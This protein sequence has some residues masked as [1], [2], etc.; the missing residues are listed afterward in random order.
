MPTLYDAGARA[1]SGLTPKIATL[2]RQPGALKTGRGTG[3]R[4]FAI[5]I[6]S[7]GDKA[8]SRPLVFEPRRS[9]VA[10]RAKITV[11]ALPRPAR[12]PAA[13]PPVRLTEAGPPPPPPPPSTPASPL[14]TQT[15]QPPQPPQIPSLPSISAAAPPAP[16]TL[17]TPQPPPAPP[18][19]PSVPAQQQPSP[20]TLGAKVQ[21][22]AI[23]PSVNP[24]APPPVNPAPPGGAAARK[25]AKQRQAA[26]A[27]S[28]ESGGDAKSAEAE[29][30]HSSDPSHSSTRLDDGR[31]AFTR[32]EQR[33]ASPLSQTALY[34]GG[35][36][37]MALAL[38]LAWSVGRPGPRRRPPEVPAPAH[39]IL[40]DRRR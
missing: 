15:L 17:A 2:D 9:F 40:R 28:E 10:Q 38:A 7:V 6:L 29:V 22:V 12:A 8:A 37:L 20:L 34:G 30:S 31:H 4:T 19:P 11:P 21:A 23:V 14:S 32:L 39:A 18:P 35:T 16:P 3:K 24:P 1:G 5:A 33:S 26:T 27:K 13:Q 25:E 36:A